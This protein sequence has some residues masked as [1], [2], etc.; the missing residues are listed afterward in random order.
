MNIVANCHHLAFTYSDKEFDTSFGIEI[1][2][3]LKDLTTKRFVIFKY[4][5]FVIIS[6]IIK[7]T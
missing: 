3:A 4:F 1:L 2:L 5:L 7:I 6:K